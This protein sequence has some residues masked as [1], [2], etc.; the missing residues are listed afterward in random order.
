MSNSIS[1]SMAVIL[2]SD[3]VCR[4]GVS[5]YIRRGQTQTANPA[6]LGMDG[7]SGTCFVSGYHSTTWWQ[8]TFGNDYI[9]TGVDIYGI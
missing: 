7:N 9:I 5:C 2:F 3:I 1:S 4:T 8:V 6:S